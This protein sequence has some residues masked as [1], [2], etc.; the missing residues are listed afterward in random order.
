MRPRFITN[1]LLAFAG[2][3]VA[4]ASQAFAPAVAGWTAFGVAVAI[5]VGL[6]LAQL[7]RRR[8]LIQRALDGLATVLTIWTVAA[9]VIFAG[10][11]LRWLT[12]GEAIGFVLLAVGGL[13]AHELSQEGVVV[14]L[15][16]RASQV[17]DLDSH[18]KEAYPTAA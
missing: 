2:A 11:A 18:R 8:G 7:D 4:V 10:A 13:V 1:M 3:F 15:G 17:D 12:L 6:G 14:S 16:T 9:S 5:L